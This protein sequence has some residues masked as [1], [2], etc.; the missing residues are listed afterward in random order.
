MA[1][2]YWYTLPCT[3]VCADTQ[4]PSIGLSTTTPPTRGPHTFQTELQ[5]CHGYLF[6]C[7]LFRGRIGACQYRCGYNTP[8]SNPLTFTGSVPCY[9]ALF[10]LMSETVRISDSRDHVKSK[11]VDV[12]RTRRILSFGWTLKFSPLTPHVIVCHCAASLSKKLSLE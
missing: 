4:R 3:C 1:D 12:M 9:V 6:S 7:I 10:I 5:N 2:W 8:L 11:S